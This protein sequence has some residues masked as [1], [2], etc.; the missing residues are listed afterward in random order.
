MQGMQ[1][2]HCCADHESH[3][4]TV[5]MVTVYIHDYIMMISRFGGT[6]CGLLIL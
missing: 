2:V 6:T 4:G 3:I 5:A 1:T